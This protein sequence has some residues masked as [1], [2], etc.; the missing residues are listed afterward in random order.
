MAFTSAHGFTGEAPREP[1]LIE[2]IKILDLAKN[3]SLESRGSFESSMDDHVFVS[4]KV[5][6]KACLENGLHF[7]TIGPMFLAS[8]KKHLGQLYFFEEM[9]KKF[10]DPKMGGATAEDCAAF[11]NNE[12]R[13]CDT[14][15]VEGNLRRRMYETVHAKL[16]ELRAW[17][18]FVDTERFND[19]R[20]QARKRAE[21]ERQREWERKQQEDIRRK[22]EAKW[23]SA[24]EDAMNDAMGGAPPPGGSFRYEDLEE[25]IRNF[26]FHYGGGRAD[27][28][29]RDAFRSRERPDP[30]P[31][32]PKP[33]GA[34]H[35]VLGVPVGANKATIKAA[36]RRLCKINH[37]DRGGSHERMAEI[38]AAKDEGLAGASS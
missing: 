4:F 24:F 31:Q 12:I 38:N 14:H 30:P 5:S 27:S 20:E 6:K 9:T 17:R 35:E 23:Q 19:L 1:T 15:G 7:H 10:Q 29:F 22:A 16:M 34:W 28:S 26:R 32:K 8:L 25:M 36:W 3:F 37:P 11:I 33:R 18:I 2:L 21:E 13:H